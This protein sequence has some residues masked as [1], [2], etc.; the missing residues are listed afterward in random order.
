MR[1]YDADFASSIDF[2]S[3]AFKISADVYVGSLACF[4]KSNQW[5]YECPYYSC[6]CRVIEAQSEAQA[7][8]SQSKSGNDIPAK[9]E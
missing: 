7:E 8:V 9:P 4:E 5:S 6:V 1:R 2:K 3:L